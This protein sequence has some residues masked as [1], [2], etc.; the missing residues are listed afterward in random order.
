MTIIAR[1]VM[2][3]IRTLMTGTVEW[4]ATD[5]LAVEHDSTFDHPGLKAAGTAPVDGGVARWTGAW[6]AEV[7]AFVD[8]AL[9]VALP[10]A[11]L[12]AGVRHIALVAVPLRIPQLA[13]EAA[14]LLGHVGSYCL[15]PGASPS[16]RICLRRFRPF[17]DAMNME[18]LVAVVTVPGGVRLFDSVEADHTFGH[19]P[20]QL[21]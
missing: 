17:L 4:F 11:H 9:C 2:A 5:P 15:A 10:A 7:H 21:F 20:D 6:M 13:A 3:D 8:A 16:S 14:I 1:P 12:P 19:A 18:D